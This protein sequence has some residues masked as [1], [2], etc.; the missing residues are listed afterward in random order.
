M[1]LIATSRRL[2]P[3]ALVLAPVLVS[4]LAAQQPRPIGPLDRELAEPFSVIASVRQ[5]SNGRVL[6]ADTREAQVHLV[7]FTAGTARLVGRQGA[8]PGEYGFPSRLLAWPADTTL[9]W[10]PQQ[11]RFLLI[12]PDGA[13]GPTIPI[14]DRG[15]HLLLG[16]LIGADP[17][18]RLIY[19]VQRRGVPGAMES[20]AEA[21][22]VRVD[23]ASGRHDTLAVLQLPRGE[24]SGART[25][26]GGMLQR[27]TNLPFA[28]RDVAAV[29]PDGRVAIVR[30]EGYRVEWVGGDAP[31]AGPPTPFRAVRITEAE[32]RAF[33]ASQVQPGHIV[34]RGGGAS[35]GVAAPRGSG[36]PAGSTEDMSGMTW[37]ATKPPFL[38]GAAMADDRGRLWVLETRAHDDPVPVHAVF[39]ARGEL[40]E[41][42]SLPRDARLVGFGPGAIYLARTDEDGLQYLQRYRR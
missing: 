22:L 12:R 32:K 1:T 17:R 13:P 35:G 3:L 40:L 41:R 33:M 24:F 2:V 31:V 7:D 21:D 15:E 10:D 38:A 29:A 6:V 42:V 8:G 14:E 26:P 5:L 39:G 27:F 37:P 4:H 18:G 9:L 36:P 19:V 30:A 28:A 25:L 23:R 34:V 11:S 20:A 16:S